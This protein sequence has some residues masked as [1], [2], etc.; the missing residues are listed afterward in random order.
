MGAVMKS[1]VTELAAA[2]IVALA[3][4]GA[5]AM[6]VLLPKTPPTL[7]RGV[8]V[9][10]TQR[11]PLNVPA[12]VSPADSDSDLPLL[13]FHEPFAIPADDGTPVAT[14]RRPSSGFDTTSEQLA[15][16]ATG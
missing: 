5:M 8:A 7:G 4:I 6:D 3:L 14:P 12:T 9:I 11:P 10:G 15:R 2:W 1:S 13:E 16:R